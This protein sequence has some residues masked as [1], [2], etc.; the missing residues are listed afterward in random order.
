MFPRPRMV[1]VRFAASI[2]SV[3]RVSSFFTSFENPVERSAQPLEAEVAIMQSPLSVRWP[4]LVI[5]SVVGWF[6]LILG[7]PEAWI[8]S[9][10]RIIRF[11]L[12]SDVTA[13]KAFIG[14]LL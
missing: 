4:S 1:S 2:V 9:A 6:A 5:S 14:A 8:T 13:S 10:I 12:L 7:C 3:T 11:A